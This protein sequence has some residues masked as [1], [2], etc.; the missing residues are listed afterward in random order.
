MRTRGAALAPVAIAL[1]ICLPSGAQ[2]EGSHAPGV[3]DLAKNPRAAEFDAVHRSVERL[4]IDAQKL[5]WHTS[6]G[7][8]KLLVALRMLEGV[9]A[10][11]TTDVRLTFDYGRVLSLLKYYERSMRVLS[12]ALTQAPQHP[13]A[14]DAYYAIAIC[15]AKLG[16]PKDEIAAYDEYLRRETDASSRANAIANR[17]EAHM[18]S[19][20][21]AAAIED[22]RA[23]LVLSPE[24]AL[25]HFSLAVAL[26]R[27]GDRTGAI[28]EAKIAVTYDAL[29]RQ[30]GSPN[31]F[32]VP[33]YDRYWY[34]ALGAMARAQQ[35]DDPATA[36]L[37]WETAA[38][39]W[40]EYIDAAGPQDRWIGFAR[41]R[42][43]STDRDLKKARARS[44]RA[45]PL[46]R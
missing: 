12:A 30:L 18:V 3:W 15:Y 22:L 46:Y 8:E 26:D 6:M 44:T 38:G 5:D 39:K 21:L 41:S 31:V 45:R 35:I 4:V 24:N 42:L 7:R 9:D 28:A 14:A 17:G 2:I 23:S 43:V 16:R 36:I 1:S 11:K 33:P 34:E 13:A 40:K 27:S 37:W 29:D 19:G 20:D 32:F 10:E 25:A